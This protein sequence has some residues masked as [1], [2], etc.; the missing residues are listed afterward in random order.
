MQA[1]AG[2]VGA[3]SAGAHPGFTA[4]GRRKKPDKW[5]QEL[6]HVTQV[7]PGDAISEPGSGFADSTHLRS[8]VPS[9]WHAGV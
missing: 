6:K 4:S 2:G 5:G 8:L 3:D 1:C 9:D 7:G